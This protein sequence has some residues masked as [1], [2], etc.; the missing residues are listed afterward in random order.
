MNVASK[1]TVVMPVYNGMP[2]LKEAIES[3]L[4]QSFQNFEFLIIDD[5]STDQSI[6]CIA[7]YEDPRIRFIRNEQNKGQ[8]RTLNRGLEL[9]QGEYVARLDQDDVCLP[10]RLEVQL[11]YMVK[12]PNLAITCTWEHTIDAYGRRVRSWKG[13]IENYG[14]FLGR[15]LLGKCPIWHPSVMF[16]REVVLRLG[17]YDPSYAPSDDFDLWARIAIQRYNAAIVPEF[18]VLQRVHGGRQSVKRFTVQYENIRRAHENAVRIFYNGPHIDILASLLR[19][20]DT[21][22]RGY[23]LRTKLKDVLPALEALLVNVKNS[24]RLN[25]EEGVTLRRVIYQRLGLGIKVGQRMLSFPSI[26]LNFIVIGLSPFLIP[27]IRA[28]ALFFYTKFFELRYPYRLMTAI[29]QKGK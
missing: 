29:F 20:D 25:A 23:K 13:E 15:I 14:A 2:Y 19:M 24:M 18:L 10:R 8:A 1:V 3:V 6:A 12:R 22:W 26:I 27:S 7:S 28:A 4:S 9:A 17:G 21:F 5:G 11:L 16:R